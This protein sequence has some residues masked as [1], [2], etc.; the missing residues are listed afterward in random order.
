MVSGTE[1]LRGSCPYL[2]NESKA[3]AQVVCN[4][5]GT[6]CAT[7]VRTDND[8][9]PEV[10]DLSFNITLQERLAVEIING[11]VKESLV[12]LTRKC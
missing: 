8:C 6:L 9:L 1:D 3:E 7:G 12:S 10:G 2:V 4:G 11:N 5:S